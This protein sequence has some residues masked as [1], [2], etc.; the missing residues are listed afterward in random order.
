MLRTQSKEGI[1]R[2]EELVFTKGT[3]VNAEF[4]TEVSQA[5]VGCIGQVVGLGVVFWAEP[6]AFQMPPDGFG[7]IEVGRI[8]A[9]KTG[10]GPV[11]PTR[12]AVVG[13]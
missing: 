7:Q 3:E 9:G 4:F 8:R 6:A 11:F 2:S 12:P 1:S 13:R 10:T 5:A